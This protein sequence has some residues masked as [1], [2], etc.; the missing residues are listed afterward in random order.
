MIARAGSAAQKEALLGPMIEGRKQ[1]ALAW[2]ERQSRY[3]L[4]DVS[5]KATK[6]AMKRVGVMSYDDA[7]DYLVR[8]Q[9]AAN[10][11][12]N[13][14]RKEGIRQ[15]IDEKSY[16]PGLGAYDKDRVKA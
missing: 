12:D 4:A 8:A 10:S 15:F 1:F 2:L 9:E 11:Y 6:D 14:G 16:K 3:N 7:E 13:T 5:L